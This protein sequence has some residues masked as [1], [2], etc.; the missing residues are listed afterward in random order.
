[1][2][3]I[4]VCPLAHIETTVRATGARSMVTL[5]NPDYPVE[6]PVAIEAARH[7]RLSLADVEIPVDEHVAPEETHVR[8]FLR[9][10]RAWDR[11][12]PL[13]IHCY[14]GVSRSTAAAMIAVCALNPTRDEH[15]VAQELR[16]AS[17]TATPNKL[18][19]RHADMLL[20]RGGRMVAAARAIGRGEDC[21][22]GAPFALEV[23]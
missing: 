10:V 6:R 14:A 20:S 17:P 2:P 11:R 4:H 9:F 16:A 19:I 18:L 5:I 21:Y 13:L 12:D 3:S 23:A 15:E 22:E 7:L 8:E 1:M